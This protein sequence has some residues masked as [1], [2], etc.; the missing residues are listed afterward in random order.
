MKKTKGK[1]SYNVIPFLN[2]YNMIAPV[3]FENLLESMQDCGY[4]TK[5][6]IEF[7]KAMWKMFIRK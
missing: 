2:E 1:Q 3:D 6:G 5:E 7:R 4:L